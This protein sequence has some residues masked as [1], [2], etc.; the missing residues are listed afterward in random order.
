MMRTMVKS[1]GFTPA[2]IH[3]LILSIIIVS[4]I[5]FVIHHKPFIGP[6]LVLLGFLPW[7]PLKAVGRGIKS[8]GADIIFGA[9]DTAFLG[10]AALV[11]ASFVGV[12]G[13]IVGGAAGDA[14]TDGFAGLFEGRMA[15][16]LRKR[17]IDEARTP[18]SSSM[19]KMSGCLIG[20]GIVLTIA[21]TIM[22]I[23]IG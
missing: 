14:V 11:G 6:V 13:A 19:G 17:G 5:I 8:V 10:I 2:L 3:A 9:I 16:F 18:L 7:I 1:E 21:W 4:V 22:R 15:Q 23:Q 12:L 20:I